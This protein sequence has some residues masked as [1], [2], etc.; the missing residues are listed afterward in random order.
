MRKG[1]LTFGEAVLARLAGGRQ[2][3]GPASG[4][5]SSASFLAENWVRLSAKN[6]ALF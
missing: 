2:D 1:F 6:D 4:M 5:V 3:S